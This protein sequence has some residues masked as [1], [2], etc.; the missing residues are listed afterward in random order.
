MTGMLPQAKTVMRKKRG[1][2][3]RAFTMAAR[4][5]GNPGLDDEARQIVA[6]WLQLNEAERR[7][8]IEAVLADQR[9]A[10]QLDDVS[11][12][13]GEA[14]QEDDASPGQE[15]EEPVV[16][17][18]GGGQVVGDGLWEPEEEKPLPFDQPQSS[19]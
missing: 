10:V 18:D 16:V 14:A 9:D 6:A 15:Q 17:A 13:G 12:V 4:A 3:L 5:A 7:R 19:D 2:P 8:V 1:A 11:A